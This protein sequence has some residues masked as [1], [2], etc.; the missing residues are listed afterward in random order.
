M[1][2]SDKPEPEDAASAVSSFTPSSTSSTAL[3]GRS[4]KDKEDIGLEMSLNLPLCPVPLLL[5]LPRFP[6]LPPRPGVF[7]LPISGDQGVFGGSGWKRAVTKEGVRI[8]QVA[9]KLASNLFVDNLLR[10][11]PPSS[12][13]QR[14]LDGH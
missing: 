10:C 2:Y 14:L 3:S 13:A 7:F 1:I 9:F 11:L 12:A 4:S 6:V 5:P 8:C